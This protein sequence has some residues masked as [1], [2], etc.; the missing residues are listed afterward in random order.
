VVALCRSWVAMTPG[1]VDHDGSD[2]GIS[3]RARFGAEALREVEVLLGLQ[4]RVVAQRDDVTLRPT[5]VLSCCV[6][7]H[8]HFALPI[9]PSLR[10]PPGHV[11]EN[12]VSS[13]SPMGST[14]L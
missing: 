12:G 3:S 8:D 14:P 5:S 7:R 6:L 13:W 2:L 1:C 11:A 10:Q 4:T 9:A